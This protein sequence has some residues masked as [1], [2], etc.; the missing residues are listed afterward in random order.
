MNP[1]APGAP[2]GRTPGAGRT[3]AV[4]VACYVAIPVVVVGG[5][6]LSFR[7]DPEMA[8]GTGDY[9]GNY[10]LLETVQ[11]GIRMA[12]AGAGLALWVATCL[13][14][15]RSRGR[16]ALWL[17]LAAAGP[18]GFAVLSMLPDRTPG[19]VDPYGRFLA[20]LG[21]YRLVPLGV[22]LFVGACTLALGG[23]VLAREAQVRLES[24]ATGM[25][26]ATIVDLQAASGGMH[27][28]AEGLVAMYLVPLLLL[29]W[30]PLFRLAA[31]GRG[32]SPQDDPGPGRPGRQEGR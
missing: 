12:A 5:A 9:Q 27:A 31:R 21:P 24:Y 20:R 8:R 6:L 1:R 2:E 13:L 3:W 22:V 10:R 17:P 16:S 11:A 4:A 25:P 15:L 32:G 26:V 30:P 14:V 7:I 23:T 29:L 28:F 18:L 19:T